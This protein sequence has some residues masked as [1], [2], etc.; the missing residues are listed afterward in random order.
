MLNKLQDIP[1]A[2]NVLKTAEITQKRFGPD[3]G[4]SHYQLIVYFEVPLSSGR[5]AEKQKWG[6]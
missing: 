2:N 1:S 5:Q 4:G 3:K 6:R